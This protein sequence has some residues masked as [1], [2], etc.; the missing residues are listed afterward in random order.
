M[1][2][3]VRALLLALMRL[4]YRPIRA[5]GLEHVP[6]EG[7]ALVVSNHPNGLLDPALVRLALRRPV[8]FLAKSTLFGNVFGRL[9]MNGFGGIPVYRSRDGEDTSK[10]DKTF[11][12]CR[13]H[14]GRGGWLALFPE[15]TSHSD[16]TMKPLKTGAARIALS[17]VAEGAV[18]GT[19][20][21]IPAGLCFDAKDDFRT[22]AA[23]TVGAPIDAVAFAKEHGTD[24]AAAEKLTAEIRRALG[25]VLLQA[26]N[27]E[28][29]RGLL[30]VAAWTDPASRA[31]LALRQVRA[32]RLADAYHELSERDPE[33]AEAIVETTR[34]LVR[35]L[36][37]IGVEDPLGLEDPPPLSVVQV[38]A[39]IV[40]LA[41]IAALG[42]L[43]AW[44]P[45]RGVGLLARRL[46][47][48]H[49][50]LVGTI[51]L[52]G[53]L[54]ILSVVYVAEA[55]ALGAWLGWAVGL[56]AVVAGPLTG[57]VALRYGERLHLRRQALKAHWLLA[58]ADQRVQAVRRRR[59]EVADVVAE[60]L[61]RDSGG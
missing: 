18:T 42:A 34:A 49:T 6:A 37:E 39:P 12:L 1:S 5:L 52:L 30:H 25:E 16:P 38:L 55:V 50:D 23:V 22:A 9:L 10:N 54:V 11:A 46:S 24:F 31:D 53:G 51:K 36:A 60:A 47:G 3:L 40:L 58:T 59:Q 33:R 44:L 7:P 57:F 2:R 45:Y 14:L 48:E 43:L 35:E 4:F 61:K 20:P 32:R 19:L 56:S 27:H 29:W 21:I 8:H 13:E 41:P 26:E 28:L 17:T 15:G